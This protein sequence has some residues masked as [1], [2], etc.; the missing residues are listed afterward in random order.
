MESSLSSLIN[1]LSEGI[2]KI[3]CKHR[4]DDKKCETCGIKYKYCGCSLEYT[5]LK[6]DLIEY[7]CLCCNKNYQQ[8]FDKKLN[9]QFFNTYKFSNHDNDRFILLLQ[10]TVCPCEYTDDWE[11]INET[12]LPGKEDFYSHLNVEYTCR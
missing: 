10:K 4:H 12:L 8:K 6:Y 11:K 3:K 2:H 7:K 5:K 9:E 1:N